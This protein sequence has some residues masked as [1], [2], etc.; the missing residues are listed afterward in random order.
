MRL[1]FGTGTIYVKNHLTERWSE[2]SLSLSWNPQGLTLSLS[3]IWTLKSEEFQELGIDS[4]KR[5]IPRS[6][7]IRPN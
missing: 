5:F 6:Q 3:K 1:F 7:N 2:F 4:A